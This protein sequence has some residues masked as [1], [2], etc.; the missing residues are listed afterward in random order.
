M[1]NLNVIKEMRIRKILILKIR[2]NPEIFG[3]YYEKRWL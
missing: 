1:I 2:I 3:K